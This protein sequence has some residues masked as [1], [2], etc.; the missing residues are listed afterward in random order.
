MRNWG[1]VD[2]RRLEVVFKASKRQRLLRI[3]SSFLWSFSWEFCCVHFTIIDT[4]VTAQQRLPCGLTEVFPKL[5][6]PNGSII[7]SQ[8][9]A[10]I[11]DS[12]KT[13]A[14]KEPS[15]SVSVAD[16]VDVQIPGPTTKV[17]ASADGPHKSLSALSFPQPQEQAGPVQHQPRCWLVDTFRN[18]LKQRGKMLVKTPQV[19]CPLVGQFWSMSCE[20]F[21]GSEVG[22]GHAGH[23]G[24][25][26]M[27]TPLLFLLPYLSQFL[28]LWLCL[29]DHLQTNYVLPNPCQYLF[30]SSP[31]WLR[32]L[33]K[34]VTMSRFQF[35]QG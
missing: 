33:C 9:W 6:K 14:W 19:P 26:L 17:T 18:I 30:Q 7:A 21:E 23:S 29:R 22:L 32:T 27:G 13:D 2:F 8:P 28:T 31:K 16:T 24:N 4:G 20:D 3:S 11:K 12:T 5:Q 15:L 10:I 25:P 1:S 34:S 35:P